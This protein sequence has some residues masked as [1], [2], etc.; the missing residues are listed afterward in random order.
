MKS[1][2]KKLLRESL[3]KSVVLYHGTPNKHD[4]NDRGQLYD[5]TFFSTNKHEASSY[6]KN[7]YEVIL[8]N[9]I[10]LF[11]STNINNAKL[12][13]SRFNELYDNYY[14]EDEEEH[15]IRTPEQIIYN[16][17]N[18]NP[19]EN[20]DGVLEWLHSNYDGVKIT[21]G[22]VLNVLIFNPLNETIKSI[23]LTNR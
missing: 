21:E 2:I 23:K 12:L 10:N 15:F 11:D 5:G 7:V 4:F 17:D 6:G 19:I 18:W 20:T 14:T 16:S 22:G 8:K 9:N 13:L 3:G 1:I